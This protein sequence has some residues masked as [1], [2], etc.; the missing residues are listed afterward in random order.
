MKE[1]YY[2]L[3]DIVIKDINEKGYFI[4]SKKE[5]KLIKE[6][7]NMSLNEQKRA[8]QFFE[9]MG[10]FNKHDKFPKIYIRSKKLKGG[11]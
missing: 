11:C 7:T 6:K 4:Y 1:Q 5:K 9:L 2:D 3:Y 10:Y 8:F